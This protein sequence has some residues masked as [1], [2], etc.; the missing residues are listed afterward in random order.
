MPDNLYR[1]NGVYYARIQVDGHDLRKSLQTKDRREAERRLKAQLASVSAYHGTVRRTFDDVMADYLLDAETTLKPRTHARYETSALMLADK[2]AGRWWDSV[3]KETVL[4]YIAERKAAGTKIPT[5]RRDLTVLSQA[6]EFAIERKWGGTNPVAQIGKRQL[7]YKAPVF[8]R[9]SARSEALAVECCY[10]NLKP[11]VRFLRATGM[12][13]DEGATLERDAVDFQRA[14]ATLP[15]T[16]NSTTRTI[17]LS[18]DALAILR[19]Q[20]AHL[21]TRLFFPAIDR[22]TKEPRPYK[23]ASTNW[24]EAL[25]RAAERA[26]KAGWKFERF[27][28][29]GMRHLYAIDYLA[30]GGNLYTLQRQLG[31]G[32]IRQTEGYLQFLSP[33]EQQAAQSGS[34]QKASHPKRFSLDEGGENG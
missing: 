12:R 22:V 4:E 19:A 17:S 30:H 33:E 34:A 16:K 20:P 29:H 31:H 14:V 6:A 28:L 21:G 7:R 1:R 24:Q 23:Q 5:I 3:T 15:E 25:K 11:L 8:R 26:A 32:S 18:P 13:L 9:P 10:G 27:P 2:F